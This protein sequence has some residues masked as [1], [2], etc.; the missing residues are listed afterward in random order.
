[1]SFAS[2]IVSCVLNISVKFST[3][4]ECPMPFITKR[5]QLNM[6]IFRKC[7]T[8]ELTFSV[9]FCKK[10]TPIDPCDIPLANRRYRQ[11]AER[12]KSIRRR[13]RFYFIR[14]E[15][16]MTRAF[17]STRKEHREPCELVPISITSKISLELGLIRILP[18]Y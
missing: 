11:R 6:K 15:Y 8:N 4:C 5:T 14:E 18:I 12:C 13:L 10:S 1:M 7:M 17:I 16:W 2:I 9:N 3:R